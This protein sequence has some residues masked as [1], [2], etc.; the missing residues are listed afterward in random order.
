MTPGKPRRAL[1]PVAWWL[2]A[3]LLA[4]AAS[5]TLNPLLLLTIVGVA[6]V[7]VAARRT[8][9][10]WAASFRA[11][12]LMGVVVLVLR[13]AFEV[14]F[15]PP[16]PGTVVMTLPSVTLPDAM[17]GV[18]LGGPVTVEGL[19]AA[20]YSGLQL[21]AIFACVGAANAL[22][23]PSRLLKS[24]PGALYE[25][26]LAVV[27]ALTLIPSAVAHLQ[28]VREARRL[29]GRS[30][31]GMRATASMSVTVLTGA[32][33]RS[34]DLAAAM[35]ARGYGR[36]RHIPLRQRR[37]T[38]AFVLTGLVAILVGGYGL[39]DVQTPGWVTLGTVTLGLALAVV[40]FRRANRRAI[41]SVYRPDPWRLAEWTT[42]A[43]GLVALTGLVV[44]GQLQPSAL[45]PV[46]SPL[47]WPALPLLAML[48]I[49]VAGLPAVLTPLPP[50]STR[51][52]EVV[53][54]PEAA[55]AQRV[56][57]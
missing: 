20:A 44:T 15:G 16:I 18:R 9:A 28:L 45:L 53:A 7:V 51:R 33:E 39:L 24:V 21:V 47:S 23:N 40:G 41:R 17:A 46:T 5:R 34:L 3:L 12:L 27:V 6:G 32:L 10:P 31:R 2:W 14:F 25:I 29:R 1:H 36:M 43:S 35:D 26:G 50:R 48:A 8:D 57:A 42:V 52:R 22:A 38:S 55:V 4:S 19:V 13:I 49:L 54:L 11:F 37:I 56:A 30:D